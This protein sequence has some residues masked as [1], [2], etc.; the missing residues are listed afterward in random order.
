MLPA[1]SQVVLRSLTGNGT[2]EYTLRGYERPLPPREINCLIYDAVTHDRIRRSF[3]ISNGRGEARDSKGAIDLAV[4]AA[5]FKAADDIKINCPGFNSVPEQDCPIDLSTERSGN[6][7][8]QGIL[9]RA[10]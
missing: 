6:V 2:L 1:G 5:F 10:R 4:P 3:T 7:A 8:P 9:P